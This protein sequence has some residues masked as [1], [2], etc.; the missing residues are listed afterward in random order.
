LDFAF[1]TWTHPNGT[2]W[3]KDLLPKK[4]P[5]CRV[6]IFGYNSNVAFDV[7]QQGIKEHANT[8]LDRLSGNREDV[9]A[10]FTFF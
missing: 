10:S 6:L 1:Q 3:P 7:T 2:F 4:I 9:K 8:L 5:N